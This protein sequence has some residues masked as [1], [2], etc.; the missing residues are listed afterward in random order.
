MH[1]AGIGVHADR[2]LCSGFHRAN[3]SASKKFL[4]LSSSF[5]LPFISCPAR[6]PAHLFCAVILDRQREDGTGWRAPPRRSILFMGILPTVSRSPESTEGPGTAVG[7][8]AALGTDRENRKPVATIGIGNTDLS[9]QCLPDAL[10]HATAK[11]PR[12]AVS[13]MEVALGQRAPGRA[14]R[15]RGIFGPVIPPCRILR[16]GVVRRLH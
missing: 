11:Q 15:R 6:R 9:Q 8:T 3:P 16:T 14:Q 7:A 12:Y 2:G 10:L 13:D 5:S 1:G 4:G